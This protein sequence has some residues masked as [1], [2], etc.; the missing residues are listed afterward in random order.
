[1]TDTNY[2]YQYFLEKS[3]GDKKPDNHKAE[4][5]PIKRLDVKPQKKEG[6]QHV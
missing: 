6:K 3:G 1:M 5:P 4:G 2:L